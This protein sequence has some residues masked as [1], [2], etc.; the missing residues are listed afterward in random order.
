MKTMASSDEAMVMASVKNFL[1]STP[2]TRKM[3]NGSGRTE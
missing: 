3:L 1:P 2:L